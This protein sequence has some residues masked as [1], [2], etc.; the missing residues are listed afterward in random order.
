V[1]YPVVVEK[2]QSPA[3]QEKKKKAFAAIQ[4]DLFALNGTKMELSA[5]K[6]KVA[7]IKTRLRQK[8]DTNATG[9]KRIRITDGEKKLLS[10]LEVD[11]NPVF[12]QVSGM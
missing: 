2:S 10:V 5:I 4:N 8:T 9:N 7:N 3:I 1:K 11:K 6:K 12:T